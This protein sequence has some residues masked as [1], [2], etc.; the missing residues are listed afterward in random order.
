MK[1]I[2][3]IM[4]AFILRIILIG[5]PGAGK[6]TQAKL[7]S[8]HFKIPHL[9]TGD[10]FRENIANKTSLGLQVQTLINQGLLVPDDVTISL[11]RNNINSEKCWSGFLLDGFPRNLY[12]A[13]ELDSFL[14]CKI[15]KVILIDVPKEI[16]IN[17]LKLRRVCANC[18]C[19]HQVI[20]NNSTINQSCS[21]CGGTLIQR[22]DDKESVVLDRISVYN[23]LIKPM[24]DYYSA[25]GILHEVNGNESIENVF[26]NICSIIR[27]TPQS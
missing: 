24:L 3:I 17:R 23:N 13:T 1:N 5:A 7:I 20:S 15:D 18:G 14:N 12:Q 4:E 26:N 9:S 19:I 8:K 27:P 2:Y 21:E 25:Q 16:I 6:G 22:E 10:M 11:V